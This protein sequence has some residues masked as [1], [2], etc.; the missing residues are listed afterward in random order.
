V[1]RYRIDIAALS[2]TRY[3]LTWAVLNKG[4]LNGCV[5]VCVSETRLSGQTELEE[6]GA[7]YTFFCMGQPV[8]QPRQAGIGF[9]IR[10]ALISQ[11][12]QRP[13][14]LSPRLMTMKL[15]LKRGRSAKLISTYAPTMSNDDADKEAFYD[16]LNSILR[17]MS[18][19]DRIFLLGDFNARVGRDAQTRPRVLGQHSVGNENSNGSLLLQTCSEHE[20]AL[21]N[22]YFQQANKYKTT[23]QNL[24]SKHWH[25]T[26]G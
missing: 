20:L 19:K 4:P 15:H 6:V 3:G 11:L 13:Q 9:A 12:E 7:G 18:F 14:G 21:T 10:T 26:P 2:E 17:T 23:W 8:S 5:C 1:A 25:K 24:H 16:N 22:T